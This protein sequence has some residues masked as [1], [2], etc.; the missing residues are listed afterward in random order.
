MC[1]PTQLGHQA[2]D[3]PN[4]T[5]PWKDIFGEEEFI[6]RPPIYESQLRERRKL[7]T[8]DEDDLAQR[9]EQYAKVRS[10]RRRS[11]AHLPPGRS[12]S[13]G[14]DGCPPPLA[15]HFKM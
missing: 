4:G 13:T 11:A 10:D 1:V 12:S 9:A 6:L 3:C 14:T 8:V 7:K 5:V 2:V 15:G